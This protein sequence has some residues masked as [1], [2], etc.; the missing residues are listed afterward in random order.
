VKSRIAAV[1]ACV[2]LGACATAEPPAGGSAVMAGDTLRG[3]VDVVGA[4]PATSIVLRTAAGDVGITGERRLLAQLAGVEVTLQGSAGGARQFEAVLVHVRAV[5]GVS[6]IDGVLERDGAG[7]VL[8]T[9]DGSRLALPHLPSALTGRAGT[10]IWL[11]GPL[12][13]APAAYGV[14]VP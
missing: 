5:D 6:A 1:F 7:F 12:D 4:E 10:R 3:V 14:I 13:R 9:A 8:R 2:I 11:A